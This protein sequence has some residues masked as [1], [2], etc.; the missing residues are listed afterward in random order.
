[1]SN[2]EIAHCWNLYLSIKEQQLDS[3]SLMENTASIKRIADLFLTLPNIVRRIIMS[4]KKIIAAATL[5]TAVGAAFSETTTTSANPETGRTR[6]EV[7]VELQQAY[8]QGLLP[9]NDAD[10]SGDHR[11]AIRKTAPRALLD[12]S[13]KTN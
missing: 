9:Q 3:A 11:F 1:V 2:A 12:T 13:V 8:A 6:A 4:I 7:I 10:L 5:L